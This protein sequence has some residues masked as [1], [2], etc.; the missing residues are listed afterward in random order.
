MSCVL[1]W[2]GGGGASRCVGG[3]GGFG[4]AAPTMFSL[5]SGGDGV[6]RLSPRPRGRSYALP[7]ALALIPEQSHVRTSYKSIDIDLWQ[8]CAR[9][10][11]DYQSCCVVSLPHLSP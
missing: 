6:T 8:A 3:K 2:A 5:G 11:N 7:L 9:A 4:N 10:T 1:V